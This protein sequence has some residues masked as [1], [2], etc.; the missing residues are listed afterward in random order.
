VI[1]Y[2]GMLS[3]RHSSTRVDNIGKGSWSSD[4]D[5]LGAEI[6]YAQHQYLA[7]TRKKS[8]DSKQESERLLFSFIESQLSLY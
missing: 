6:N 7:Q 4:E 5:L 1:A 3:G 8:R 2:I